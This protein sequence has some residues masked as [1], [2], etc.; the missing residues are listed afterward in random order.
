[1]ISCAQRCSSARCSLRVASVGAWRIFQGRLTSR[2]PPT[3]TYLR[4]STIN[5]DI[6]VL[7]GHTRRGLDGMLRWGALAYTFGVVRT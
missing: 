3:L 2:S 6:R 7:T 4:R 5:H 1:M